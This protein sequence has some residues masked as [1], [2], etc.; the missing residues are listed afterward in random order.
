MVAGAEFVA[1]VRMLVQGSI[2]LLLVHPAAAQQVEMLC[3]AA[4]PV[5]R[6]LNIFEIFSKQAGMQNLF[7]VFEPLAGDPPSQQS[8]QAFID[9][10]F[11]AN[12]LR[13]GS[14]LAVNLRC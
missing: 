7:N 10:E 12:L 2:V 1:P 5:R 8:M 11:D 3:E 13:S 6:Y 4:K 14:I 9:A